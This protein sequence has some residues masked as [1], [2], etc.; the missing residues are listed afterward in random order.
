MKNFL[1]LVSLFL[2][3]NLSAQIKV[4]SSGYVGINNTNPTYRL[5]VL[6]NVR[7]LVNS[8]AFSFD[9]YKFYPLIGNISLGNSSYMW[10][11]IWADYAYFNASPVIMSDASIKTNITGFS[12]AMDKI[13]LLNPVQYDF[14][15]D[16]Q[17]SL[18]DKSKTSKQFGFLAQE[19]QVVFPEI[20]TQREDGLLGVRYTELIPVLVQALKEQQE[21]IDI[22]NTRIAELEKSSK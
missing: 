14:K 6:G 22:L 2:V 9:G 17:P 12:S 10:Y 3:I 15:A 7:V 11:E 19:L 18:T 20:V 5:D 4:N 8:N 21:Q 1:L 16:F 13:K